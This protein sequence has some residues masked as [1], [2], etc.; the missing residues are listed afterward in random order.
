MRHRLLI[1]LLHRLRASNW[2][3]DGVADAVGAD[4]QSALESFESEVLTAPVVGNEA[5]DGARY[6]KSRLVGL[7]EFMTTVHAEMAT[8]M[9]AARHGVS[10]NGADLFTTTFPCHECTRHVVAAG[11]RSVTYVEPYPKSLA[12]ELAGHAI[13]VESAEDLKVPFMPF[14]GVAPSRFLE[15]FIAPRRKDSSGQTIEPEFEKNGPRVHPADMDGRLSV[16]KEQ[17][18]V[19]EL[20]SVMENAGLYWT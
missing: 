16:D 20:G 17:G 19:F 10:V 1:D 6:G 15:L 13:S 8:L 4:P 9:D 11:I 2:L 7:I 12:R 5:D 18:I 3:S 14:V